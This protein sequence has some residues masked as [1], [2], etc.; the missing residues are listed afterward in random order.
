MLKQPLPSPM[1]HIRFI[2]SCSSPLSPTAFAALESKFK[3]PVL[4]A[5]AM[6]E[7]SH[8]MTSNPLPPAKRKPGS[9]GLPQFLELQI[10]DDRA[11]VLPQGQIG[12]ICV[13]GEN[14]TSGYI[15][16]DVASPFTADGYLRTG[17]Q[18]YKDEEGYLFLTGRIKELINKGGEKISPIELDNTF[19]QHPAITEA[20]SFAIEDEFYGQDVAVAVVLKPGSE[21]RADELTSWFAQRAA[22]FKIPKKVYFTDNMPKTATGKVQRRLVAKAMVDQEKKEEEETS[23]KLTAKETGTSSIAELR[24]GLPFI[25]EVWRKLLLRFWHS[26]F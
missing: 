6:T 25:F 23:M 12:E 10:M 19:S 5:Y 9:V 21:L 22:K 1:P 26:F 4:E 24:R 13:R 11:K 17:D 14:V 20:V 2:R 3:A 7:A 8:Q 16:E 15:G 18:G